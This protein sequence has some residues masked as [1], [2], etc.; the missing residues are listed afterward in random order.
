MTRVLSCKNVWLFVFKSNR[1]PNEEGQILTNIMVIAIIIIFHI[2]SSLNRFPILPENSLAVPFPRLPSQVHHG[3]DGRQAELRHRLQ[4]FGPLQAGAAKVEV[5]ETQGL[6]HQADL[7]GIESP[8]CMEV[9]IAMGVPPAV[10][11]LYGKIPLKCM[12]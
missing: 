9:S 10:D 3:L 8:I 6:A 1:T 12:I 7:R 2:F 4:R 11:D 5:D